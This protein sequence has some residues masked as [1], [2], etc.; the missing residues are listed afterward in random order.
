MAPKYLVPV[1][2][3]LAA[4]TGRLGCSAFTTPL[5]EVRLPPAAPTPRRRAR[6]PRPLRAVGA[7]D[8]EADAGPST[9]A[10]AATEPSLRRVAR[11]EKYARLPI[12]PVWQGVLL[13][14]ASKLFGPEVVAGWEDAVGGRVCPNFFVP[15]ETSPFVLLVHHRHAFMN[16]DPVRYIQRTFFP[17]GFPA[18]PHRGFVTVTYILQGGFTHRDSLGIKQR[19]GAERRH[20]G[21]H[22]QW[23]T[24]G[25]GI[26]HEEMWD[27]APDENDEGNWLWTSS[28]E[29]YQIW[30]NLPAAHK[31]DPPNAFLLKAHPVDDALTAP[32]P[33]TTP[34]ITSED[35]STVTTV[36]AGAHDGVR[37]P[38]DC[39]T[40][41]SILRI[42]FA[43]KEPSTWT[44][45]LPST[46]ETAI[47]YVRGGSICIDGERV[48][49][50]HTAYLTPDGARLE[51][52]SSDGADVLLLSGRPLNEPIAS[53]GS[54]VMNTQGEI[55]NAYMDFQRGFMGVPWDHKLDDD[56]WRD[57]VRR[58]PSKY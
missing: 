12:W 52:E 58:H 47:L 25:A 46:H 39:P 35:G 8:T 49:P 15:T 57:H 55:Q 24:A 36:V 18:H 56:E 29:L 16:W 31:M 26:Q 43:K 20:E 4:A 28:Q 22:V 44:H 19:Y 41:A 30:L 9:A 53:Q 3:A 27:V 5:P 11:V 51:V 1:A 21:N 54:M 34:I 45:R 2:V 7:T 23:L 6:T 13:F 33:G 42:Q 32:L 48:P 14:V 37:A 40:D 50:H 38:V 10:T 17:E